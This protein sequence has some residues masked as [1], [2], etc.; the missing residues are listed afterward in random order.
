MTAKSGWR[1]LRIMRAQPASSAVKA[2]QLAME[3]R[4]QTGT[5]LVLAMVVLGAVVLRAGVHNVFT[6][7]WWRH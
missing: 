6:P 1:M 5:A 4:L 7:G 3:R 2:R